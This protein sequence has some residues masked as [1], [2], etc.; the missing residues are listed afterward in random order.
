M[1]LDS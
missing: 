1:L